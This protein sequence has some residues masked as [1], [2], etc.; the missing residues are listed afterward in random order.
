[1]GSLLP[2]HTFQTSL[3]WTSPDF[4]QHK[5]QGRL[6]RLTPYD[7]FKYCSRIRQQNSIKRRI[8]HSPQDIDDIKDVL[9]NKSLC[10]KQVGYRKKHYNIQETDNRINF[11]FSG[12]IRFFLQQ[13]HHKKLRILY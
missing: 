7:F 10:S 4:R 6:Q 13:R 11:A 9:R 1:M 3:R 5:W 12:I 2:R 8:R